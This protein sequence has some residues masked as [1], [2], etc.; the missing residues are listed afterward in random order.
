MPLV[1]RP[2]ARGDRGLPEVL[3]PAQ[4]VDGVVVDEL[5]TLD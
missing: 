2:G 1:F 4:M 3:V 5:N